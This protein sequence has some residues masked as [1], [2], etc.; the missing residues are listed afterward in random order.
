MSLRSD[1][2]SLLNHFICLKEVNFS[3]KPKYFHDYCVQNH[4]LKLLIGEFSK[5]TIRTACSTSS[6]YL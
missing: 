5:Q 4:P 6:L 2:L 1:R 3:L